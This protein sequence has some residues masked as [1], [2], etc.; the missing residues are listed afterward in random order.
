MKSRFFLFRVFFVSF[1]LLF[2]Y[3][4]AFAMK[5][6]PNCSKT[7]AE[8]VNFCPFDGSEL[9][10][11]PEAEVVTVDFDIEP[12][13]ARIE[14]DNE[15]VMSKNIQMHIGQTYKVK[16]EAK[17]YRTQNIEVLPVSKGNFKFSLDLGKLSPETKKAQKISLIGDNKDKDMVEIKPGAYII[18]N[19]RGNHDERPLRKVETNGFWI[20]KYEVTCAQYQR[21][22]EDVRKHG[23]KWCHSNEPKHKDHTPYHTYAWALRFSWVGGQPPKGMLDVPVVLVDWFDAYAYARWAGKRLPTEDE[24]EIAARGGDG[25]EYPWGNTFSLDICNVGDQPVAVG[26]Y[27]DGVSPWG[28]HDMAGNVSEWTATAYEA[29]P[30]DA[31]EFYGK[32]GLPIIRGGSWDDTSKGCRSSARDVRRSPLYRS[33]T[34]GFRCVSDKPPEEI[35]SHR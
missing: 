2:F 24:W 8:D 7:F 32:Y 23:H 10:E 28:A 21:F 22:L 25:R 1:C 18:G 30:R 17:G 27:P 6:C 9:S 11:I 15:I 31:F 12:I 13:N 16:I 19:D 4:S 29:N 3:S 26:L 14:I 5:I 35:E 33:T 20:D 34:V